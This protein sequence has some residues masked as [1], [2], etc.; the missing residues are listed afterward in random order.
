MTYHCSD[1]SNLDEIAHYESGL[2]AFV[3]GEMDA[4]R[5]QAMRLQMGVYGQRQ[6][7]VH[8]TRIKLPGGDLTP[9]QLDKIAEVLETLSD[10]D[11]V[12]VTTRQDIQIHYIPLAKTPA[13]LRAY[14]EV[15]L[16]TREACANTIR[17]MSACALSGVCPKEHT[18]VSQHLQGAMKHFLRNPLN[19]QL[20]RKFKISFSGCETDCA[21]GMIHDMGVV[22]VEK[23]GQFGFKVLAGGGLG[24]KPHEAIVVEEFVAEERLIAVMEAVVA[25]HNRY[26]DRVKRAKSRIK[27][28]VDKFGADGFREKYREELSR[29]EAALAVEK[30]PRGTWQVG[31]RS[32]FSALGAPRA[33]LEQKQGG[34]YVLPIALPLGDLTA[35]QLRGLS[36]LFQRHGIGHLRATQDQN[37]IALDVPQALLAPLQ[38]GIVEL[39]LGAPQAGDNIVA[40]P[41]TSTCRLGITSSMTV[42]PKLQNAKLADLRVRVSGCHNGCAQPET[43]DIGIYGEGR[44]IHGKLLPHYQMYLGGDGRAGF[45]LALKGPSIPTMRIEQAIDR[46]RDTFFAEREG[47]QETFFHYVRRVGIARFNELLHDL[48][49]VTPEEV[50]LLAHDHGDSADFKVLQLGGGECSGAAQLQTMSAFFDAAHERNYRDA[51]VFQRKYSEA[52]HCAR[53]IARDIGQALVSLGG[54]TKQDELAAIAA[55]MQRVLP[56]NKALAEAFAVLAGELMRPEEDLDAV[57]S[58]RIYAELDRWTIAAAEL[59]LERDKHLDL[60]GALPVGAVPIKFHPKS[61]ATVTA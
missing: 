6:P 50:P 51:F 56:A 21:Q 7:G 43:G 41:G 16:T 22:A 8:M 42:A 28:L 2:N 30:A 14:A 17:N 45:G 35:P 59:A 3:N 19:Q 13:A 11:V 61:A 15:G 33:A 54:G 36:A 10:N 44:R 38:A 5:F 57:E 34:T 23:D 47:D 25:L 37:L 24:H 31:E 26:S 20:P 55:E 27:F 4:E 39:G 12:H 40:C 49:V 46:L 29:T 53:V 9:V 1:L 48:T 32:D 58:Q 18:D 60:S 52:V